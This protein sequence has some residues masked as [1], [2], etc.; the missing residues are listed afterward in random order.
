MESFDHLF[1]H[2]SLV[3]D[4][5]LAVHEDAMLDIDWCGLH[6]KQQP[7]RDN[8]QTEKISSGLKS[9]H[10]QLKSPEKTNI[11]KNWLSEWLLWKRIAELYYTTFNLS[12]QPP[13]S[14]PSSTELSAYGIV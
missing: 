10:F 3:T 4:I 14:G 13:V 5:R 12:E 2:G 1:Q 7:K 9:N 11:N 8:N 6:V